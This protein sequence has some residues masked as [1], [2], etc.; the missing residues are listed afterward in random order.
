MKVIIERKP[1]YEFGKDIYLPLL[2]ARSFN[3]QQLF[4]Y[5]FFFVQRVFYELSVVKVTK[6]T[7]V[8]RF[9]TDL[10]AQ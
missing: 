1:Q 4:F 3:F 2:I 9:F 5:D 6:Y 8:N 10:L 7:T